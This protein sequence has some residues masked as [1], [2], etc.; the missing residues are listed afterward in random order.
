[1]KDEKPL[2]FESGYFQDSRVSNYKDYTKRKFEYL[3]ADLA[4]VLAISRNSL[5]LDFGCATGGLVAALRLIGFNNVIGT[6]ISY[7]AI[8][9]GRETFGLSK[10]ILHHYNRQLLEGFFEIVLFLDV[11]EHV[12]TEELD[13]LLGCLAT[14]RI[15]VRVPV[16]AQEGEHFVLEVSRNDKTH[17]QIHSREWWGDLFKRYGFVLDVVLQTKTIHDGEGVLSRTYRRG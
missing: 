12:N 1:M 9:H 16:S 14:D 7:W 8:N 10:E 3:A 11:L 5:V 15:A 13:N 4:C 6:D 2:G 17:I